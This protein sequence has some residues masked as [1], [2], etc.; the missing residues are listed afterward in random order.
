MKDNR[1]QLSVV[2]K[3]ENVGTLALTKN[4]TV[5]FQYKDTWLKNGFSISPFSLPLSDN[6]FYPDNIYLDGLHGV[7]YDSLPD[8]WG[9]LIV[10]RM[11]KSKGINPSNINVLDRLAIIGTNGM[12]AL[13]YVPEYE[14]ITRDNR[15]T[16]DELAE[17]CSNILASAPAENIDE[18]FR[19]AGSSGGARPK[20][21]VEIDGEEWIIKFQ[22]SHDEPNSGEREFRYSE[23][24]RECGIHMSETRLFPSQNGRGYFGTKRFDRPKKHMVSAAGLLEVNFNYST[25]DYKEL[26]KLTNILTNGN[27]KEIKEMYVRMC[28]NVLFHNQDDH[29]KNF[30]FLYDDMTE[31]WHISPAYDLTY[32]TTAFNEHTT[33][34]NG[35]GSEIQDSDLLKVGTASGL[36]KLFCL[37]TI[38]KIKDIKEKSIIK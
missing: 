4:G 12:G 31:T 14:L 21:Y 8:N 9:R 6:I 25:C 2:Y 36:G 22:Y 28:F 1:K 7:F 23:I 15:L 10:D 26:L 18:I 16:I 24:A 38:A 33:T 37:E 35:K 30:A 20:A 19:A 34:V 17:E 32:V 5:A 3:G 11:L 13:E 27:T 29:M